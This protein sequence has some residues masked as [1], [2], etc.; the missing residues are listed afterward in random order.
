MSRS[1]LLLVFA[2]GASSFG[3]QAAN[4]PET[5]IRDAPA[6]FSTGVNLVLVPVVVR[7]R[8]GKAIGTLTKDDFQ[9][10]DKG[11]P[12]VIT[13]FSIEKPETPVIPAE[14]AAEVKLDENGAEKAAGIPGPASAPIAE[15]FIAYLF[16]DVH[17]NGGDLARVRIAAEKH[18]A[19][20]MGPA[21]RAAIYTTSGETT[22]EFTDDREKLH[23]ALTRIHPLTG[24]QAVTVGADCPPIDY[25]M[26]DL[27]LNKSDPQAMQAAVGEALAC[28]ALPQATNQ[29][30]AQQNTQQAQQAVRSVASRI[31]SVGTSQTQ[32]TLAKL[33]DLVR[34]MS[35]APGS[36]AIILVSPGFVLTIDHRDDENDIIDRAIRA[37]ITI[38]SL[39]AR[40]LYAITPGGDAST[41]PLAQTAGMIT[42]ISQYQHDSAIAGAD[43]MAELAGATGGAFFENDNGLEEG[44]NQIAAQPEFIYVL[45]FSP[46]NLKLD[47][48]YHGLKV[49]LKNSSGLTM[50]FRRGYYTQK[51]LKDPAEQAKEEIREAVFSREEMQDLPVDLHLQ[52]F[53]SS[54]TTARIT[55]LAHLDL[56]P[57]HFRKADGRNK[58]TVTI[59]SGLFDRNGN[60]VTGSQKILDLNLLDKTYEA[61]PAGGVTVRTNLDVKPGSYVVRLVV[62]D[63]EGQSMAARNGVV[64]IP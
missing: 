3:Q 61:L 56:R 21:T 60:L 10:F 24:I 31:L 29:Q 2:L 50:Q 4:A 42:L 6:I 27:I 37:N 53:K 22:L 34:R 39:D 45:G 9:V 15:R 48:S 58:D 25:Y 18:L 55:V 57:L 40:G 26:A 19:T 33:K 11:K 32:F 59:V 17:L 63:S 23:E 7:D 52:F 44:F 49:T 12:Q 64:E 5:S 41:G 20:S 1:Y 62:R 28:L 30:Q 47:G 46:Q 35:A 38:S 14:V 36:R 13:K 54:D 8:Q 16:D 43:I 51:H